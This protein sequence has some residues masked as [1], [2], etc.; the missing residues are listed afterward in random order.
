MAR[1]DVYANSGRH[2]DTTPYLLDVQSDLLD[3][4]DSCMV[5]PLR[6]LA[7]FPKV[8]VPDRL[9]PVLHIGGQDLLLETPKMGAVPRRILAAPVASISS[10]QETIIAALDFLFQGY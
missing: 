2:A 8:R 10:Q 4:L 5:I 1:F 3:G 9:M 6:R 7:V